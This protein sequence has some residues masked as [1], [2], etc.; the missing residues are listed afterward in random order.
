[1]RGN[2]KL[3]GNFKE[4]YESSSFSGRKCDMFRPRTRRHSVVKK[5]EVFVFEKDV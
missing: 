4:Y 3:S 1:M 2:Q 5:M